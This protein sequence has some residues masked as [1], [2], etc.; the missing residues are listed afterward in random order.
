LV[1]LDWVPHGW[2]VGVAGAS[3]GARVVVLLLTCGGWRLIAGIKKGGGGWIVTAAL[4]ILSWFLL[5][6]R[7]KI[8][9]KKVLINFLLQK[10]IIFEIQIVKIMNK[11]M[12]TRLLC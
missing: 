8:T 4:F 9:L 7:R 2:I 3:V 6:I 10:V 11:I 12:L 1:G 5:L